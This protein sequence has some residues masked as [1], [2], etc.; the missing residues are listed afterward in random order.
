MA[1]DMVR[2]MGRDTGTGT[3]RDNQ[4]KRP[5]FLSNKLR[6]LLPIVLK[7]LPCIMLKISFFRVIYHSKPSFKSECGKFIS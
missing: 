5:L 6:R 4:G 1:K 3:G 2:D 7:I